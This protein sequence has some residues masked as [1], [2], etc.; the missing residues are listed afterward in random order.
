M[1]QD[2]YFIIGPLPVSSSTGPHH[3]LPPHLAGLPYP[4]LHTY[5]ALLAFAGVLAVLQAVFT[6]DALIRLSILAPMGLIIRGPRADLWHYPTGFGSLAQVLDKGLLGFWGR[7]WHQTFRAAF[8]APAIALGLSPW[9]TALIAF[10]HSGLLHA[11]GSATSAG[12]DKTD[13]WG[14]FAFFVL[15]FLGVCVQ[16][17][18]GRALRASGLGPV[19]FRQRW[20]RRAGNLA[21]VVA[22]LVATQGLFVDDLARGGIWLLEPVPASPLR[23]MGYG[24]PGDHWLRWGKAEI[25]PWWHWGRRWWE[26]G[27]AL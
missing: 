12:R 13:P 17:A 24:Q 27:I 25:V 18:L 4:V 2:P 10:V 16:E 14:P 15:A 5:R 7:W 19:V 3:L 11:A 23:A 1:M 26:C 22:W 6:F 21:F 8:T 9:P 20:V